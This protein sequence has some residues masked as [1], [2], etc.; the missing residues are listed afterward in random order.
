M[1]AAV[2]WLWEPGFNR[3]LETSKSRD[4]LLAVVLCSRP[5]TAS[6]QDFKLHFAGILGG[7]CLCI[8]VASI[9][10]FTL[11]IIAR[12]STIHGSITYQGLVRFPHNTYPYSCIV[13]SSSCI[14][15]GNALLLFLVR[16]SVACQRSFNVCPDTFLEPPI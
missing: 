14:Q 2:D 5:V 12:Q 1:L 9:E 3:C 13:G 4:V 11:N 6:L 7:L 10:Y 16:S 15:I 8:V